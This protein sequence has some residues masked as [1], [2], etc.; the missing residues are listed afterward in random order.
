MQSEL[1][2]TTDAALSHLAAHVCWAAAEHEVKPP[3]AREK[4]EEARRWR[5]QPTAPDDDRSHLSSRRRRQ[6][7]E[8]TPAHASRPAQ[9]ACS[10][11][12]IVGMQSMHRAAAENSG[13]GRGMEAREGL[14]DRP[15]DQ[16]GLFRDL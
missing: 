3:R 2:A 4:E 1:T 15:R 13:E 16:V 11:G 12:C 5:R 9:A 14:R 6:L 7:C 8:R 10:D